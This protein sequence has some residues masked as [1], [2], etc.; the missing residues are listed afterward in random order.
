MKNF[1]A[2][3]KKRRSTRRYLNKEVS[4][5][6]ILTCIEAAR[7]APSGENVQPWRFIVIDDPELRDRLTTEACKGIY[8]PTS[9]IKKAPVIIAVLADTSFLVHKVGAFL[10]KVPFYLLDIG[11]ACEHLVLQAEELGLGTCYIGWY[12][13]SRSKKVLGLSKKN[14]LVLLISFGYPDEGKKKPQKRKTIEE[15]VSFNRKP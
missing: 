6:D 2:L 10:Q 8:R 11:M 1:Q 12:H 5:K 15:I 13:V 4:R 3:V 9:F 14:K 7:L